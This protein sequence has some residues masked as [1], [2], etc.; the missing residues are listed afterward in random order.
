M[1]RNL[2]AHATLRRLF[3]VVCIPACLSASFLA[4]PPATAADDPASGDSQPAQDSAK[5]LLRY[6]FRKGEI[7]RTQVIHMATTETRI[8]GNLQSSRSRGVSVKEWRFVEVGDEGMTFEH[9]VTE[10]VMSNQV[11]G[12]AEVTYNSKTNGDKEPPVEYQSVADSIGKTIAVVTMTADGEIVKQE[13]KYQQHSF[14]LGQMV[15]PL[16]KQPVGLGDA[17]FFPT[18]I[19]ASLKNGQKKRIKTRQ[20]YSL[21]KVSNGV[22]TIDVVTQVLTPIQSPEVEVQLMQQITKGSVKFDIDA[23][24]L[25]SQRMDWDESAVGF[26]G[27]Q[28]TMEYLARFEEKQLAGGQLP[29]SYRSASAPI[30]GPSPNASPSEPQSKTVKTAEKRDADGAK[31]E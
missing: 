10:A 21:S 4:A 12:R 29:K 28:S 19:T 15:F 7:V 2:A 9:V 16:P 22:A 18:E 17:W 3:F 8:R 26:N 5:H 11:T 20:R 24:R 31:R 14:G 1:K 25:I 30:V 6:K 13:Q 27:A 23:G